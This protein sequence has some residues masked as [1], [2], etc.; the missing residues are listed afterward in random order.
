MA[1]RRAILVCATVAVIGGAALFTS[2]HIVELIRD[3]L[4]EETETKHYRTREDASTEISRGWLSPL[5]ESI[6]DIRVKRN[7]DYG[8]M[9][10]QFS[11]APEEFPNGFPAMTLLDATAARQAGPRWIVRRCE[12]VPREIR[13]G[14][15][16][17][18]LS[19]G[20]QLYRHQQNRWKIWY[21]LIQPE[22]GVAYGWNSNADDHARQRQN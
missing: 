7:I 18:F 10:F 9:V 1:R 2:R 6:R 3:P 4:F 14:H 15:T 13:T 22:K 17:V 21:L 20:F 19:R 16:D 8:T 5:P 11:F 12:W